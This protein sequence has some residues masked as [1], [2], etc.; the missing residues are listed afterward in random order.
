MEDPKL[1]KKSL[2]LVSEDTVFKD[3]Q[4]KIGA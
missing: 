1:K 2:Y 3:K 4:K